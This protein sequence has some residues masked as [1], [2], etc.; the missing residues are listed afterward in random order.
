MHQSRRLTPAQPEML[1]HTAYTPIMLGVLLAHGLHDRAWH[2]R[3]ATVLGLRFMPWAAAAV[4]VVVCT[5]APV[6]LTGWPRLSLHLAM[7]VLVGSCVIREDHW[8]MP[9]LRLPPLV[10]IGVLSYGIYLLHMLCRHGCKAILDKAGLPA[11]PWLFPL[12]LGVTVVVAW[13]SFTFYEAR[14][15]KLKDRFTS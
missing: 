1:K 2:E 15:L 13:L 9:L 12:T 3:L 6:D 14:F 10:R 4:V 11:E 5:V 7:V 8:M